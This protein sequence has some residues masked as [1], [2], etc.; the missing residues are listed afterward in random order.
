MKKLILLR[1]AKSD[2]SGWARSLDFVSDVERPLSKRGQDACKKVSELFIARQLKV[3]L[4][5]YSSAQRA[6]D[7]FTLIKDAL[8]FSAHKKNSALYT[9]NSRSLMDIISSKSD[10]INHFLLIG[11]NPAIEDLVVDLVSTEHNLKELEI[12]RSKYPTG[13]VAFIELNISRWRDL[14]KNCGRLIEFVRP[15]DIEISKDIQTQ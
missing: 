11:H 12:L 5:E 14:Q 6:A 9:F 15:K 13:A 10:E 1:H 7:T 4:V 3:D 8:L 2:W